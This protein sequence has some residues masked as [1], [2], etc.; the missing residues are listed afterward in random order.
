MKPNFISSSSSSDEDGENAHMIY[1]YNQFM[2]DMQRRIDNNNMLIQYLRDRQSPQIYRGSVPGHIV[3]NRDRE[4]AYARLYNDY[5]ANN[6]LYNETMFRRRFRMSR[7]L[8]LRIVDAVKEHD[9]YFVQRPGGTG[10]LGLSSLQKVKAAIR[11]LAYGVPADACDEYVKLSESSAIKSLKRFCRAIIEVFS[12]QYLRS[13]TTSD[14]ARLLYIGEQRGFPGML[15]SL[16][17]MHWKWKNCPTGWSGSYSGRSGSPTIILEAVADYDLWIWHAYFGLPGSNNDINVLD[18]SHLFYNLTQGIAPPTYYVIQGKEYNMCYYLADGIY[19][20]WSTIV[21]TIHEPRTPKT[22]YFAMRQEACRKDVERAFGVLQSRFSIVAGPVRYWDKEVLHD[23]MITCIILHNM[24]VE[25]ERDLSSPIE[26]A[27][28]AP[29]PEVKMT[30]NEDVRFQEY[31]TRYAAIRN[32]NAHL[33]LRNA[34]VD[35][36][37]ENFSNTQ[38]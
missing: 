4:G 38:S 34:L 24:I 6:P 11:I 19:P 37:W 7:P 23:I 33:E 18:S 20:K 28:N 30:T 12:T 32:K 26:V 16:D 17:C 15:G 25:D 1:T 27:R 3:I 2:Q 5:F 13:P 10:R 36:L 9:D 22:K 29:Q 31:L 35:H 14:I 21:Q 8:F